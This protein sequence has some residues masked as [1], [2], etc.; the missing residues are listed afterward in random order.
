MSRSGWVLLLA[1]LAGCAH[2]R[3]APPTGIYFVMVD[4]FEDGDRSNDAEIDRADPQ[5]FHGGDL[6]GVIERL[7]WVQALGFDTVW[8]S[9]I[10]KMRT[11]KW[12]GHGAFHGYW[13][14]DLSALE[15]RFGDEL[16]LA[17]LRRE[18][19]RRGMKLVLDVVLNHVGP[20]APLL[21][22]HPDWFHRRGGV[23]DWNDREQ[24]V[25]HDVHGLPDLATEKPE[26]FAWLLASSK[27]WLELARPDGFRLDA[28][29]HLPIEFWARFNGAFDG[30]FTRLG[31]LLDGDPSTVARTWREG[32]FTSMFD[33]PLAF[34]VADVFC[35]GESPAKLAAA[36]TNDRRYPDP[37]KL[38]TLV[39]NHDL[40]RILSVCGGDVE[41]T[42]QALTFLFAMRGI[43]S[44][45]WGTEVG[46]EGAKEP[47]NRPSMRFVEHPLRE[48]VR[49]QMKQRLES[50]ALRSGAAVPVEVTPARVVIARIA[51]DG[52]TVHV[53]VEAGRVQVST[54]RPAERWLVEQWRTGART[55][56]VTFRGKGSVVGSGPELGDW[57][58]A[59]ARPMPVTIELPLNGAFEL[60]RIVDGAWED[61]P[62]RVL[63]VTEATSTVDW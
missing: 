25:M 15:P 56:A 11:E 1:A 13:T 62:N 54:A 10:F 37:S 23:T 2:Q 19:D 36:L 20:D 50:P 32:R 16:L 63:F 44:L 45:T 43:P 35:R 40:P 28:V 52:S 59:K 51:D 27:R 31:E 55:R 4:R 7:D 5:A 6:Q 26:V 49:A 18:L 39:D 42:K 46:L 8:L 57:D 41:K 34:A 24:L 3:P 14:W 60:K 17:R 33:F 38:V 53:V 58:Q 29:K 61:G 9:P 47:E 21:T 22:A 30:D 12:F 48:H